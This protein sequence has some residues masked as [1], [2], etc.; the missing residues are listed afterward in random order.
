MNRKIRQMLLVVA[1]IGT[2]LPA[3]AVELAQK[4]LR[5]WSVE[6]RG[7]SGTVQPENLLS[8][9]IHP[10][11]AG[12]EVVGGTQ[13]LTVS[14]PDAQKK[15]ISTASYRFAAKNADATATVFAPATPAATGT[16]KYPNPND[17]KFQCKGAQKTYYKTEEGFLGCPSVGGACPAGEPCFDPARIG[18]RF[19]SAQG[20]NLGIANVGSQRVVV[21]GSQVQGGYSN[22]VEGEVD[23]SVYGVTVYNTAG[24]RLWAKSWAA[25]S[26]GYEILPVLSGV[27]AFHSVGVDQLRVGARKQGGVG[28]TFRYQYYNLLTG[29]LAGQASFVVNKP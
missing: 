29:A 9:D 12:L 23:I 11:L 26:S 20:F 5:I 8:L 24:K 7:Y 16:L 10:G 17:P 19:P 25:Q 22:S 4:S 27:A 3:Q 21:F 18:D 1:G 14:A 15:V 2:A 13:K 6:N 28:D